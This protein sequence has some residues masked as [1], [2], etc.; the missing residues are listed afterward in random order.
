MK[1]SLSA[2][3]R[4]GSGPAQQLPGR[5]TPEGVARRRSKRLVGT[6]GGPS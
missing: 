3:G 2:G 6:P 1:L 5:T 4:L